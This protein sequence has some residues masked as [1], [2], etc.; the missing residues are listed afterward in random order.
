MLFAVA[1]VAFI[2]ASIR[3]LVDSIA[4]LLIVNVLAFVSFGVGPYV[5]PIAVHVPI[6]PLTRVAATINPLDQAAA[7]DLVLGPLSVVARTIGPQ[8]RAKAL[9]DAFDE[10]AQIVRPLR[11]RFFA[12][13]VHLTLP[14]EASVQDSVS[15]FVD[16]IA[17]H[18][19][20]GPTSFIDISVWICELAGNTRLVAAPCA[21][22]RRS[23]LPCHRA[24]TVAKTPKP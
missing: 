9:F 1:P 12:F 17:A 15:V 7:T 18:Q 13:V 5:L 16:T 23:V 10:I 2:D 6:P 19:V 8:I 24:L 21:C 20:L 14:P 3:P 22:I 4:M 11:P